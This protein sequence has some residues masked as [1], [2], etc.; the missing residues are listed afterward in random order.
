MNTSPLVAGPTTL[1]P[2]GLDART[3]GAL[4]SCVREAFGPFGAIVTD[5]DPGAVDHVELLVAG[6]SAPLGFTFPVSGVA[7]FACDGVDRAIAFTFLDATGASVDD[8]C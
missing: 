7:P 3:W 4:V 2:A 1:A 5:R 8:L 6:S